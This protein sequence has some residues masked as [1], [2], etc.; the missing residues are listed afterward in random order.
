MA[1]LEKITALFGL[2]LLLSGAMMMGDLIGGF[3]GA[4]AGGMIGLGVFSCFGWISIQ[5]E[6]LC[7]KH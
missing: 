6:R 4:V 1:G 3:P 5:M 7:G 2:S